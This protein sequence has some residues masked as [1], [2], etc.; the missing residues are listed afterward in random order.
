MGGPSKQFPQ[1]KKKNEDE[2][3]K[4]MSK[5]FK[6][7]TLSANAQKIGAGNHKLSLRIFPQFPSVADVDPKSILCIFFKQGLCTKGWVWYA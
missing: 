7:V 6:P 2:D 1:S 4:D 5:I 3:L